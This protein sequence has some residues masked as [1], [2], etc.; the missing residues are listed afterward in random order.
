VTEATFIDKESLKALGFE[1]EEEALSLLIDAFSKTK[2]AKY[3]RP[4]L[5]LKEKYAFYPT[6]P[7]SCAQW[8]SDPYYFGHIGSS[9]WDV[10]KKDFLD[11]MEANPRPLRVVLGGA[12]GWG[13]TFLSCIILA[14]LLYELGCLRNPQAYYGLALGTRI[15]FM[16]LAVTATHARRV[17]F[18]QLRDM[19][20][21][22]PWF[23]ERMRRRQDIQSL[24]YFPQR[25]IS[26]APGSSSELAPLGEN[27]FGGVI[28]E[29]N[30]FPVTV[31]SKKIHNPAEREWDQAKKI[32][33][34]V[35]RRMESRYQRHGRVPGILILNSSAKY[36]DDFLEKIIAE[37]DPNTVVI[38]HSSWETKP[39]HRYSGEKFHVFVGD[40]WSSPHLIQSEE[41]LKTFTEKGRVI[42]VPVE[43]KPYFVKDLEGAIRDFIGINLRSL[44]RFMTNDEKIRECADTKIPMPFS[45]IYGNGIVSTDLPSALKLSKLMNPIVNMKKYGPQS[46][47]NP[48]APR[49]CHID[50]GLTNDACGIAVCHIASIK[51]V[52]RTREG[53]RAEVV[54]EVQP[55]IV[56]DL[57]MR[58]IPPLE[59]EIQIEDVRQLVHD[60]AHQCGFRF[61][62]ITYD[63]FQSRDSQ[64]LL[65]K[66]FGEDI[67][68]YLSVDRTSDQYNVLKETIY[69]GRFK[70]YYYEPLF[71]ELRQLIRDQKTGKVNHPPNGSKDVSDAVAGAVWNAITNMDLSIV[72]EVQKGVMEHPMSEKEELDKSTRDWLLDRPAHKKTEAELDEED[73]L[74]G[75]TDDE[76]LKEMDEEDK[77][78]KKP[79][80]KITEGW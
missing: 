51:E 16:N 37:N 20:D 76:L 60:L 12:I 49:F 36:P 79:R 61:M 54:Q 70:C 30:F 33:D 25:S 39:Q 74:D 31:G 44:N 27:L 24:V 11:I 21:E 7:V 6:D 80:A 19:I 59:G 42:A 78:K 52:M 48:Q 28:E 18:E 50:L 8:I 62:K 47:I 58:I 3:L 17:L 65:K 15:A 68:G 45:S 56:A 5:Y 64:Q 69:E 40:A 57:I 26:V 63:Q 71:R 9:M 1:S 29:A 32:H 13:K 22:S 38:I 43:L 75:V 41:E 73:F 34:A 46:L 35:W 14:R 66:R 72:D 4:S 67:V 2:S 55:V 23:S 53:E 10:L 77:A